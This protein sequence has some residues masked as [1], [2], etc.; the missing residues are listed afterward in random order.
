MSK[1]RRRYPPSELDVD[2]AELTVAEPEDHAAGVKAVAVSMR[3]SLHHM[4][5]IR[6]LRTLVKLNQPD[7]FDCMSCAWPDP[8]PEHRHKAEFCENGAKAVAEEA[9]TARA[10]PAFFAE[11]SIADLNARSEHWLGQQGRITHP[12][13]KRPGGTH[14][15]P[16]DWEAAFAI[17]AQHL[18]ALDHPDQA[19]FYTSGRTSNEAA[20]V[21][22]LFVRAF[23]TN[24]LPDCSN[25][26]HES[27]SVA[28]AEAIG[29]GKASVTLDDVYDAQLLVLAGQN[30]GTNHPRMLSALEVA[31][32]RGAKILTIN[33]LR[34]AGLLN[35]RNPQVPRGVV[36]RGTELSDLHLPIKINGDLAL[37]QAFGHLLVKWGALDEAFI[38]HHTHGFESW[39]S[40]ISDLDWDFVTT[41]TG[42]SRDQITEAAQLL[43]GSSATVFCWAMGLTQHHNSV[44]AIKE[45]CNVAFAQGNIGKPGA[46]L[47]PVRGHSNVQGDRTMGIW[48]RPPKQFLD[49]LQNEFGFD[50]PRH[51]GYDTVD[52]IRA[53]RDRKAQ[54][55]IGLGGNFVQAAPDTDVT[56]AALQE[57]DPNGPRV[58]QDQ[59]I[60]PGLWRHSPDTPHS[61]PDRDRR[62]G[63]WTTVR[64]SRGLHLRR[65]CIARATDTGKSGPALRGIDC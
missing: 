22:Q 1:P 57:C 45:I 46:G 50:P 41:T 37:F 13:V 35:F 17:I 29:I 11:H 43:C 27:T 63:N 30:P 44:A 9:T 21:Y 39:R 53:L 12:M 42:L 34:E 20:F 61:W 62:A 28:L 4:G 55:F 59:P 31:K 15:V 38:S 49:A 14:Y 3:R 54:V 32:R 58:H 48:E 25:M 24:N 47:L 10:T 65:P 19:L 40:H 8:D 52:S 5:P 6:S 51:H 60:S 33:P 36:G 7:G 23:G 2:T 64:Y 18:K 56:S 16:I 26:C